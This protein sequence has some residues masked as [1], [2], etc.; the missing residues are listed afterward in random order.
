VKTYFHSV[1][2][3]T[4]K[5]ISTEK[6]TFL[7]ARQELGLI[8]GHALLG[9]ISTEN[10]CTKLVYESSSSSRI[11]ACLDPCLTRHSVTLDTPYFLKHVFGCLL[12][13]VKLGKYSR[14]FVG[15]LRKKLSHLSR[16]I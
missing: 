1:V 13:L 14:I 12:R 3:N 7:F 15:W 8:N 9:L 5:T 6:K 16:S 2:C 4:H 10:G 11:R